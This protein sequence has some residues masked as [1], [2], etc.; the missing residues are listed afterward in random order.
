MTIT[1]EDVLHVA[2]LARLTLSQ[3]AM[4]KLPDQ[5][6]TILDYVETLNQIDTSGVLPTSHAITLTNAL[7]DDTPSGSLAREQALANAPEKEDGAFIVPS[8]IG[9]RS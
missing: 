3:E 6:T 2:K 4:D 5:I 1:K 7:R 9:E 8:I